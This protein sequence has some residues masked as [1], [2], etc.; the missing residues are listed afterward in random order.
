MS[1]F[2]PVSVPKSISASAAPERSTGSKSLKPKVGVTD[3]AYDL[4]A[5]AAIEGDDV[6]QAIGLMKT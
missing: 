3:V 2:T 4:K 6:P 1:M 5:R